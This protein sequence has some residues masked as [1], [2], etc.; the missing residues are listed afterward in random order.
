MTGGYHLSWLGTLLMTNP[1]AS[2]PALR[3]HDQHPGPEK[4][5]Q[6]CSPG[7][8]CL[9]LA[10]DPTVLCRGPQETALSEPQFLLLAI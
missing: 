7:N 5:V 6:D 3:T 2:Y 1:P 9:V 4:E 8:S 10:W